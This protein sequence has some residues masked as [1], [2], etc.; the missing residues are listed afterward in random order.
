V[1]AKGLV[2]AGVAAGRRAGHRGVV[3]RR[4]VDYGLYR[5]ATLLKPNR[6][7]LA[8]ATQM[9][10]GRDEEIVAAARAANADSFIRTLPQGYESA[11]GERGVKLSGGQRQRIAIARA[12]LK[13]PRILILDEATSA[14]DSESE[15]LVQEALERLMANRTTFII[16]HRLS[17]VKV[18]NRIVALAGGRVIEQGT[19]DQLMALGGLY[20]RLYTLQYNRD[21]L[22]AL[23]TGSVDV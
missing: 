10:V 20:Y 1:F 3:D 7:E 21:T 11:V 23:P 8:E 15:G 13:N 4:G 14:L 18:A 2:S 19:H 22:A 9:P 16:A 6:R 12:I 17:T 5:G